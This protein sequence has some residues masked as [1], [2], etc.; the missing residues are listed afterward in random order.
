MLQ[1]QLTRS[2][3]S[4]APSHGTRSVSW[5]QAEGYINCKSAPNPMGSEKPKG[6]CCCWL[7]LRASLIKRR[8]SKIVEYI[9]ANER[10]EGVGMGHDSRNMEL[11]EQL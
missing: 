3:G 8:A 6:R 7:C 5:C 1:Q 9:A 2:L 10:Y 4:Q 11:I